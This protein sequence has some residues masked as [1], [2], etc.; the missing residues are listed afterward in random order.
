MTG[1][2]LRAIRCAH[3][4]S[5]AAFGNI[6]GYHKN[7]IYRLERGEE[8]SAPIQITQRFEKLVHNMFPPQSVKKHEKT[9]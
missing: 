3:H 2:E 5:Q 9:P 8:L 7:Y 4:L 1:Q 6:L